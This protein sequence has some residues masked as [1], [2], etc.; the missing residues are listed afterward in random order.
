MHVGATLVVARVSQRT[1]GAHKGRPYEPI[2]YQ[3]D[4]ASA[5]Q[6]LPQVSRR[7]QR[8]LLLH[9]LDTYS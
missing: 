7:P 8:E 5:Y 9:L 6:S 3:T 4:T 1:Q 2:T